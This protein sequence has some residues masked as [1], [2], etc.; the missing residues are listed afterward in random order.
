MAN[1]KITGLVELTSVADTDWL[2]VVDVSDTTMASTGTNKKVKA[3]R[4]MQTNGTANTMSADLNMNNN[5]INTAGTIG[6][7][8]ISATKVNVLGNGG[9][10]VVGDGTNTAAYMSVASARALFGYD[11]STYAVVQ[12][13]GSKGI[14]FAVNNATFASGTVATVGTD[15]VWN[16]GNHDLVNISNLAI[17]TVT[18]GFNLHVVGTSTDAISLALD[19]KAASA[20]RYTIQSTGSAAA[21][22]AG[23]LEI[24]S[25]GQPASN[26][27]SFDGP[28]GRLGIGFSNP[29]YKLDVNG[30]A[31][32]SSFPTSSDQ[33]LKEDIHR[34]NLTQTLKSKLNQINAYTFRWK[35]NYAGVDEFK[36]GDGVTKDLQ[37]GF[38]AQEVQ[39]AVPQLVTTWKHVGKDG[40]T[41]EDALAVDYTRFVPILWEAV[42]ELYQENNSLK[43][44]I[45]TLEN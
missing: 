4:F 26:R 16:F 23:Y 27:L 39:A 30:Q 21:P 34:L 25:T 8:T 11:G 15:G 43:Q 40:E 42:K 13:G 3:S 33:R 28:N 45:T 35:D 24:L 32:A 18:A 19:N 1:S 10:L 38:I 29:S 5:D 9:N 36:R 44:R 41:L 22:G 37:V 31:H 12:G 6:A 7:G 2:L 20:T 17:G 14:A